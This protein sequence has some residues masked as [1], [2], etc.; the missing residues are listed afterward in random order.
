MYCCYV[1]NNHCEKSKLYKKC[2]GNFLKVCLQLLIA[3]K[4]R[5]KIV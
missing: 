4:E 1:I 3:E 2:S 5:D